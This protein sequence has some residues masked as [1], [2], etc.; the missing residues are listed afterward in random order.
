[1]G[2]GSHIIMSN[3][4]KSDW[5]LTK[6]ESYQMNTWDFPSIIKKSSTTKIYVEWNESIFHVTEDDQGKAEYTDNEGKRFLIHATR[7]KRYGFNIKIEFLDYFSVYHQPGKPFD[8]GW[9]HDHDMNFIMV[10]DKNNRHLANAGTAKNWMHDARHI[11]KNKKLSSICI[12]GSHNSGMNKAILTKS[13]LECNTK[14]QSFNIKKQLDYG[15]RY[16]DIRPYKQDG[17][18]YAGHYTYN[19]HIGWVGASGLT[20]T[21]IVN[22]IN[23]FLSEGWKE[24]IILNISHGYNFD[25]DRSL[26]SLDGKNFIKELKKIKFLYQGKEDP[27]H[28]KLEDILYGPNKPIVIINIQNATDW[29]ILREKNAFRKETIVSD[30]SDMDD[31]WKMRD[32]QLKKMSE[33]STQYYKLSWTLTQTDTEA[34]ACEFN[35]AKS[36]IGLAKTP[37]EKLIH[38]L[39]NRVSDN[40]THY[41]KI[42]SVDDVT[43]NDAAIL[44]YA[45]NLLS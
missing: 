3:G 43:N 36:I 35:M 19:N 39:F 9:K 15:I 34:V 25:K 6:S 26:D 1:M 18:F 21:E 12:P 8:L 7:T 28:T 38:D 5:T 14:T 4:T 22:Q 24:V 27:F 17:E 42:I 44:S 31:Y 13:G 11:L 10:G 2:Q 32:D 33:Y 41:P 29:I 45:I 20:I 16:F 40:P 23:D 30:Y 37:K